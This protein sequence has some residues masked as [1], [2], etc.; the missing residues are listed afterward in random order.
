MTRL[1]YTLLLLCAMLLA[2]CGSPASRVEDYGEELYMPQYAS[3]F[4]IL[5]RGDGG[6]VVIET[7]TPWQGSDS[8]TATRLFISRHGEKPPHGFEGQVL[9]GDARRL[10]AMSSTHVAMLDA[11]GAVETVVGVSGL[12]FIF[13]P[14]IH[15]H[16]QSIGDVG[17]EGNVNYELLMSLSPDLV[18]LYGV[19]G[20]HLM[21]G[22][23]AELGIPYMYVGDYLEDSPLGKAEW[24]VALAEVLGRRAEGESAFAE[25]PVRYNTLRDSVASLALDAPSV[26]LNVPYGDSWFLPPVGGYLPQLIRDAGA[27]YIYDKADGN[28]S[29]VIDGEE[30]FLLTSRADMWLNVGD[31][32]TMDELRARFPLF[33]DMRCVRNGDVYNNTARTN[34]GGGNDYFESAVVHPDVVL[35]DL[36]AIFHPELVRGDSLVYHKRLK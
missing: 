2:A 21:Q 25:I 19:N 26:M 22:K 28:E 16:R 30:A 4:R 31:I 14:Y 1:K 11:L 36:V 32:N 27:A 23:L 35:R 34:G 20:E 29:V 5:G 10:V 3:G 13:N 18:L 12:D 24:M 33:A 6:S 8:T 7:L 15:A 17:Y 9:T